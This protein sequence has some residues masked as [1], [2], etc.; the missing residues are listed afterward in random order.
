MGLEDQ[1]IHKSSLA[2]VQVTNYRNV[3]YKLSEAS[4]LQEEPRG[5]FNMEPKARLSFVRT[6]CRSGSLAY[7]FLL[8]S[9]SEP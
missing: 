2:V 8:Q 1:H 4:H 3:P 7:P 9:I 5:I 6:L